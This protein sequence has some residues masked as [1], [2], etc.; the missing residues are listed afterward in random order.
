MSEQ[1]SREQGLVIV[2]AQWGDEGKGKL[3][4]LYAEQ[5]DVVVRYQGGT[6]AGHTLVVNGVKTVL[7][8]IPSGILHP[9][10][11]CV[12]G[13]GCVVDPVALVAEM[14][15]LVAAG[16]DVSPARLCISHAAPAIL[17]VH[18]RLDRA[19][20]GAA[21]DAR[22]GTTGRGIG[23][24]YEDAVSR[25]G[26]RLGDLA[27]PQRLRQRV[28]G[29]LFEKNA[30]LAAYGQAPVT[31]ADILEPLEAVRDR[32]VPYLADA[33][34]EL[35]ARRQ[36]GERLLFEGAQG[37]LLDVWHGTYPFVTSSSTVAANAAVG[38]GLG[39]QAIGRVLGVTKAYATRVGAGPFPTELDDAV[40]A[41]IRE[42]GR[43][44]GATTGRPRRCG[45][46][47]L[48]ALRYAAR[49]NGLTSLAL[50]KLDVLQGF[51]TLKVCTEY[52]WRGR[53]YEEMPTEPAAW[54]ALVPVYAELPGFTEDLR[55][56]RRMGDLPATARDYVERISAWTGLPIELVSVGPGRDENVVR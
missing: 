13:N 15:E 34:A 28:D 48:P 49:I 23:P 44:F 18:K 12:I 35:A 50:M 43:E 22:I 1:G 27:D 41:R 46:L 39:P 3:V 38:S 24:A 9:G 47:D 42:V 17:D 5:A 11:R 31:A 14:D 53:T 2:G 21:G 37:A 6:N 7:H 52:T 16:V 54:S 51:E 33:G 25:H 36:A 10:K 55:A 4:D 32:I 8:L 20:E 40:G 26:V 56:A 30:L 45:W 29:L 19:R